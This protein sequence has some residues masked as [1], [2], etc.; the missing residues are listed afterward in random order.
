MVCDC[1]TTLA[2]TEFK[3]ARADSRSTDSP[4]E[5]AHLLIG[6]YS[7]SPLNSVLVCMPCFRPSPQRVLTL[8]IETRQLSRLRSSDPFTKSR[9]VTRLTR[10]SLKTSIRTNLCCRGQ[11]DPGVRQSV[12][13]SFSVRRWDVAGSWEKHTEPPPRAGNGVATGGQATE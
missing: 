5:F 9:N 7:F 8:T 6:P 11:A 12:S 1:R 4:P 3:S 10:H 2:A 13:Q